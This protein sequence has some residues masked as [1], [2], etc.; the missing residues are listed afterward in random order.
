MTVL[1]FASTLGL[2]LS[3]LGCSESSTQRSPTAPTPPTATPPPPQPSNLVT[4]WGIVVDPSGEC[5]EGATV[6]V[7]AGPVLVGQKATQQL[8]CD[9]TRFTG[10]FQFDDPV[11]V[12]VWEA[13]TL[14]ASAPGY[15]SQ[16]QNLSQWPWDRILTF[17]LVPTG[18]SGARHLTSDTA[19]RSERLRLAV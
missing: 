5:I 13:M 7:V 12:N 2:T 6:E 4:L 8:P 9:L 15:V 18:L 10:G 3:I 14:R 17:T 1:R 16:E 11:H 19:K